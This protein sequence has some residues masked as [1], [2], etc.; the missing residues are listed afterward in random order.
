MLDG[1]PRGLATAVTVTVSAGTGADG[2]EAAD[3]ASVTPFTLTIAAGSRSGTADFTFTPVDDD[4]DE[5]DETVAVGGSAVGL[6]VEAADLAIRED[7]ARGIVLSKTAVSPTEG[8]AGETY[9]VTLAS[10]PTGNVTVF[11]DAPTGTDVRVTPASRIFTPSSWENPQTFTVTSVDDPDS[12]DITGLAIAHRVDD[13]NDKVNAEG[14]IGHAVAGTGEYA[15]VTAAPVEVVVVDDD[16]TEPGAPNLTEAKPGY[17]EVRLA[18]QAPADDGG[19][20]IDG[21]EVSVDGGAWTP[22]GSVARARTVT[23]L[24][25]EVTYRFRVTLTLSSPFGAQIADGTATGTIVNTDPIPKAWIARFGRTVAEQVIDAVEARMRAPRSPGVELSLA[26]QRVGGSVAPDGTVPTDDV[27]QA[28][29]GRNLPAQAR[30]RA[31]HRRARTV[32]ATNDAPRP[33]RRPRYGL[34]NTEPASVGA[35]PVPYALRAISASAMA[36]PNCS[37]GRA[38]RIMPSPMTKAG[39]PRTPR[40]LAKMAFRSIGAS[41]EGSSMSRTSR[42]ASRPTER[43]TA[44]MR[45]RSKGPSAPNNSP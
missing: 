41:R 44:R 38:P 33:R 13:N 3:F 39:I 30:A 24:V 43:A 27:A 32:V 1:A 22:T 34:D 23:G 16:K 5:G 17:E 40:A 18:W 25:N 37:S 28:G 4:V 42:S 11:A 14:R 19:H 6:A 31:H 7:D 20:P 21:W 29:A 36:V 12:S 15:G 26:G 10:K 8:E 35:A 2:A 45:S 9:G